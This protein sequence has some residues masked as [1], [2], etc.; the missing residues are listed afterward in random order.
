MLR[1]HWLPAVVGLAAVLVGGVQPALA[2]ADART[3]ASAYG[4]MSVF[5]LNVAAGN[6]GVP[7][8]PDAEQTFKDAFSN[9][10]ATLYTSLSADDQQALDA[11]PLL[12]AQIHQVW[13]NLPVD[14]RLALR[15][16]WASSVQNMV[17][18][19]PCDLFDGMARAQLLPS[20]DAYKQTNVARLRQCWRDHPELTRDSQERAS[21]SGSPVTAGVGDHATYMAMFNANM[22][23]FTAGMNTASMGTATYTWK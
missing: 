20:F 17:A 6:D 3:V 9:Q 7:Q 21:V 14:Q 12:D 13:P 22:L 4:D 23:S 16:D 2:Q 10:F 5:I 11:L 8:Q 18:D 15:N 1:I 19:A